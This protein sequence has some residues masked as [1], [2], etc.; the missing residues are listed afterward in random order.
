MKGIDG[1]ARTNG[2]DDV[3][4]LLPVD[5]AVVRANV[6]HL[7]ILIARV[8][9]IALFTRRQLVIVA[10]LEKIGFQGAVSLRHAAKRGQRRHEQIVAEAQADDFRQRL[11]VFL[12]AEFL[13]FALAELENAHGVARDRGVA[14]VEL[15]EVVAEVGE[16]GG[17]EDCG[18]GGGGIR[19]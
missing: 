13:H 14:V 15:R 3:R 10:I 9:G 16:E 2:T 12:H 1:G 7:R 6:R 17:D 19:A 4:D 8:D 11:R 18:G 5:A